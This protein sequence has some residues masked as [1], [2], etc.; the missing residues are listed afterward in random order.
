MI[1]RWSNERAAGKGGIASL[2]TTERARPA[3]PERN[4]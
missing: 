1:I 2:L 4:R 3:L